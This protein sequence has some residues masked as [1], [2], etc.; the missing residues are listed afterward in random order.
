[1]VVAT[2]DRVLEQLGAG[3]FLYRY[4]PQVDDGRAGPDNPDL[5]ASLWAVRALAALGR[6]DKAHERMEAVIGTGGEL[7]L[8]AEAIDPL[9]GELMGNL[10]ATSVHLAVIDAAIALSAGPA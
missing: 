8:L 3:P 9:A 10:P 4:P 2:V 7:G 5:L 6:W 1:V